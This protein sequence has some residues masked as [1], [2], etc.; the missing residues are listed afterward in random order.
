MKSVIPAHVFSARRLVLMVAL[1]GAAAAIV[2]G[3]YQYMA[4][5]GRGSKIPQV[6][7]DFEEANWGYEV[8][9][10]KSSTNIDGQDRQPGGISANRRIYESTYRGQPDV[11]RL[12]DTPAN[13]IPGSKKSLYLRTLHSGPPNRPTFKMQQD[14]LLVNVSSVI[15]TVSVSQSPSI[16][17]RVFIPEWH[18]WEKRTGSSFGFRAETEG[19]KFSMNGGN[20]FFKRGRSMMKQETTWPGFFIQFNSKTDGQNKEDSAILLIRADENGQDI[21]GPRITESGCWWTLGMSFTPDGYV[22]YY[23]SPG[24]DP[25]TEKDHVATTKPYGHGVDHVNTFFFNV[26]NIDNGRTWSTPWIVDDPAMFYGNNYGG[27]AGNP[28]F[29]R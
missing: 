4:V 11:V 14:D 19:M 7:D 21:L 10:E 3:Q 12:I 15:G 22:H 23:A 8:N 5:P 1:L 28:G 29:R 18:A 27:Y 20:G 6:G 25:L 13:G 9:G 26:V 17:V 2:Q 24:V 16:T